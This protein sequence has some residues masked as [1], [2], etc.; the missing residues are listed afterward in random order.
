M[1]YR[2]AIV[3]SAACAACSSSTLP[4]G[5]VELMA[6]RVSVTPT[7]IGP[8]DTTHIHVVSTNATSGPAEF[9]SC[10]APTFWVFSESGSPL[11]VSDCLAPATIRI[12]GGDSLV[13]D[14]FFTTRS[15]SGTV[16]V[17]AG[18]YTLRGGWPI[19]GELEAVS[20]PVTL[21]VLAQSL[22]CTG[23]SVPPG[24]RI[25][26]FSRTLGFRHASIPAGIAA[27]REIGDRYG[28]TVEDT[29]AP[30]AFTDD[31][32]ARFA[33]V[34]FLNTTGDVLDAS[35]Q[36]AFERYIRAGGSF[37]G[38]HSASDTEYDWA[39][40]GELVG[41]YFASH[42]AIQQATVR[43]E[44]ADHPSTRC[45]PD[46]WIRTDEWYDFRA[47][48]ASSVTVLAAVD[49]ST[50]QGAT[51]GPPHPIAWYHPFDGGR[52]WYTAMGHTEESYAEPAFLDHLA[53]GMLW[54]AAGN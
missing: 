36:S 16:V 9:E 27:V 2:L 22:D 21:D 42:P 3:M 41:A 54:A 24:T 31:T 39:W 51:M 46:P 13:A 19:D 30:E 34:V 8:D 50:Y 18:R 47:R 17:P 25:L 15:P 48:P 38:V 44:E 32:L 43:I 10:P 53:G 23:T 26:V 1:G 6:T 40:Y 45:L 29:E 28:M 4:G 37:V 12:D 35:Q 11:I 20:N 5:G 7:A 52:A 33:A 49:E 14:R